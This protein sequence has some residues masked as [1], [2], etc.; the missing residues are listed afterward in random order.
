MNGAQSGP[1]HISPKKGFLRGK[2]LQKLVMFYAAG[3]AAQ[4]TFNDGVI[5]QCRGYG[6]VFEGYNTG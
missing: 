2:P 4:I 3:T 6:A 1:T 5:N